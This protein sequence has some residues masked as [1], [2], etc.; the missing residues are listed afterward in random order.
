[1]YKEIN[2]LEQL[3]ETVAAK[4]ILKKIAFQDMDFRAVADDA[5]EC[6]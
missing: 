6:W 1:M 4:G 2:T 5:W 3:R